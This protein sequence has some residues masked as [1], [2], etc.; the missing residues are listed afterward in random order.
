MCSL[1]D[2]LFSQMDWLAMHLR[3][4]VTSAFAPQGKEG[5]ELPPDSSALFSSVGEKGIYLASQDVAI[6]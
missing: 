6:W 1:V 3:T 5:L 2:D 4:R